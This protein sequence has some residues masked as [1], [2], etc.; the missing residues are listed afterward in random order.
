[1]KA[2]SNEYV[3]VHSVEDIRKKFANGSFYSAFPDFY[4][5]EEYFDE[6]ISFLEK[7]GFKVWNDGE[8]TTVTV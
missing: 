4:A 7:S 8:E 5:N 6:A 3:L 2:M 1:M